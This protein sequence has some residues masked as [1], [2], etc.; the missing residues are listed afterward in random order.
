MYILY[1]IILF[2]AAIFIVPYFLLKIIFTGKYRKSIISKLGGKQVKILTD[3]KNGPR[4]WIHAVSVGEVTAAAPIVSSLKMKRPETKII[5]STSTETGQEMAFRFIKGADA[6]VYFPL[7]IPFVVRKII[8]SAKAD[9]FVLVETE[10]WPNFLRVCKEHQMKALMVNG[11]ISP[12]SYRRYLKTTFF[13]KRILDNL[14]EAGMISRIDAERIKTI[15]LDS[16]KVKVLGNAKYDGL[17]SMVSPV[18]QNEIVLRFN[19]RENE[20]FF[21]AGSTHE[22]EEKIV[23]SVYQDII[24]RCPDFNLIIVPRHIER[25]GDVVNLLQQANFNDVIKLSDM[26]NG[27][28]RINERIIIVDVIG[29]LFKVYSLATIVYCGGS[30]V[31]KGGQNILEAAAWGKVIFYGPS[32]EDFSQEKALLEDAG[33]GITVRNKEE[34]SQGIINLLNHPEEIISRGE[35]GREVVLSNIGASAR[36]ADLIS[37]YI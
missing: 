6:I 12:R 13:W 18:L 11:R 26:N 35:K 4:I 23:I 31:P 25:T 9:V 28:Q 20:K 10:L 19:V 33:C 27:R 32:M 29:E 8:K 7:D 17:A 21:V 24:K 14:D 2:V 1:N 34:L 37:R 22:G 30:L 3:L 16:A 36:Y 15:G 5:F